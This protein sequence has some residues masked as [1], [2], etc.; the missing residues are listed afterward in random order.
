M[1]N[2]ADAIIK[3]NQLEACDQCC[4]C[5]AR[6]NT[7]PKD[8]KNSPFLYKSCIESTAPYGYETSDLKNMYLSKTQLECRRFTPVITQAQ[9]LQGGYQNW[10]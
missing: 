7:L 4:A 10:N 3:T 1:V 6:L 5:P 9:L 8:E 2:N